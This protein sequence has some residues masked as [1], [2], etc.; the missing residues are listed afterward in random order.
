MGYGKESVSGEKVEGKGGATAHL[1]RLKVDV[2]LRRKGKVS[3]A[4]RKEKSKN[5]NA[6]SSLYPR[7]SRWFHSR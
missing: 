7:P 5:S 2:D 4:R 3:R 6:P 1:E